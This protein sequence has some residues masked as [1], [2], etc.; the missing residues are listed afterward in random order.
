[1]YSM[2]KKAKSRRPCLY[3]RGCCAY[4]SGP[5]SPDHAYGRDLGI[6]YCSDREEHTTMSRK[7]LT[8]FALNYCSSSH[9]LFPVSQIGTKFKGDKEIEKDINQ[10]HIYL[11]TERPRIS[12]VKDTIFYASGKLSGKASYKIEGNDQI[13]DFDLDFPLYDGADSVRLGKYPYREIETY[14]S[15]N[16]EETIRIFP[17]FLLAS[18]YSHQDV[19]IFKKL[20]VLYVG[21]AYG[22]G[23]R[24]ALQRLESH[25]TLQK[26][27]SQLP[28]KYPDSEIIIALF[29]Y[30]IE[31]PIAH[32]SMSPHFKNAIGGD[33]DLD[34]FKKITQKPISKK[35]A[36][37]IIEAG[38]IRYFQPEYNEIFKIKFPSIKHKTLKSCMDLDFTALCV[39]INTEDSRHM[40]M[41]NTR[42]P[43][44]HHI[45]QFDLV[46][47]QNRA[48]FFQAYPNQQLDPEII[49]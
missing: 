8:E 35:Q 30:N 27:L 42:H 7:Y 5:P 40:L 15:L 9:Y 29:K 18:N 16:P 1:M 14:N 3:G 44:E 2:L 38:L 23:N 33:E 19:A 21:Q 26:I 46:S 32:I 12:F 22:D 36:V 28:E 49:S 24:S 48:S 10:C 31:K 13:F 11:I 4:D 47:T 43:S 17:S 39:E 6:L 37:T 45:S 41:S 25:S 20:N 34:Q